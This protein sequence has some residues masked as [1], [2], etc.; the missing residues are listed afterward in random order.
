LAQGRPS[1]ETLKK[2]Q[3]EFIQ[4]A[5]QPVLLLAFR[6]Y[7]ALTHQDLIALKQRRVN[8]RRVYVANPY[9]L[10]D[11]AFKLNDEFRARA[12]HAA[13]LRYLTQLVEIA[14]LQAGYR[15]AKQ[16]QG[17]KKPA[18]DLTKPLVRFHC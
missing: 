7:R 14:K 12:C 15:A 16:R 2:L 6:S 5:A 17:S 18:V 4:E 3:A 10:P 8:Y 9:G 1:E 13:Y 11:G